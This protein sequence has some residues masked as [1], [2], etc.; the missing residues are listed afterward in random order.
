MWVVF[1]QELKAFFHSIVAHVFALVFL[2]GSG[3]VLWFFPSSNVLAYGYADMGA[4]FSFAPYAF[5]LLVPALTM[6][7]FSEEYRQGTMELLFT[8]ATKLSAIVWGKYLAVVTLLGL[9]LLPSLSYYIG[10]YYLAQPIGNVDHAHIW[11]AYIGLWLLGTSFAAVGICCSAWF[12]HQGV[13]FILT[14]GICFI[15]YIGIGAL[16][17]LDTPLSSWS[18]AW[19]RELSLLEHYKALSQGVIASWE[20]VFFIGFAAI[21]VLL[22][23]AYLKATRQSARRG[24]WKENVWIEAFWRMGVVGIG[25]QIGM[26][27][28]SYGHVRWDMTE[29]KRFSLS[30]ASRE[31]LARLEAP[32]L[33]EF[34]LHGELPAGFDR[35]RKEALFFLETMSRYSDKIQVRIMKPSDA[36]GKALNRYIQSMA[37]LGVEPTHLNYTSPAGVHTQRWIFPGVA[38]YYQGKQQGITF[39]RG[40]GR[41]SAEEKLNSA[42]EG[43]EYRLMKGISK[44]LQPKKRAIGIVDKNILSEAM[45]NSVRLA[46]GEEYTLWDI[47]LTK[48]RKSAALSCAM[49]TA[50]GST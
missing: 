45:I 27:W 7:S 17:S 26:M 8:S 31:I 15:L 36:E 39:L 28:L 33:I 40:K 10:L 34:Y 29:E 44:M 48:T 5:L 38:F 47:P 13:A 21:W 18:S 1:E 9:C 43:L 4:F 25:L 2:L 20:V 30:K 6:R 3:L 42:I 23:Y 12:S 41:E 50:S 16:L 37:R 22:A 14:S 32:L 35:L 19:A 46:L 11:G 24:G 49:D